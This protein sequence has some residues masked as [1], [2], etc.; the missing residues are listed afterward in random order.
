MTNDA[1][2]PIILERQGCFKTN[3]IIPNAWYEGKQFNTPLPMVASCPKSC[4]PCHA[5]P[6]FINPNPT[7]ESINQKRR[8]GASNYT[9]IL[10][11]YHSS[12]SSAP[13][14]LLF[15]PHHQ[16]P[17]HTS[18]LFYT[19]SLLHNKHCVGINTKTTS[20]P[21]SYDRDV[22]ATG[23]I[24]YHHSKHLHLLDHLMHNVKPCYVASQ[25]LYRYIHMW[26]YHVWMGPF[27]PQLTWNPVVIG[28]AFDIEGG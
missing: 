21:S 27:R 13:V 18:I 20:L 2:P 23:S 6:C 11:R 1:T 9:T 8:L 25:W 16:T 22:W 7:N 10:P 26:F 12:Q 17:K 5:C 19:Q 4:Q 24:I 15:L 14:L 3:I 28:Q